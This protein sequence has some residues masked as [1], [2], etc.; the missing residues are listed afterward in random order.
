[1]PAAINAHVRLLLDWST[2]MINTLLIVDQTN[3]K[4]T[5]AVADCSVETDGWT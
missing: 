3:K 4:I 2:I 1:M 5:A